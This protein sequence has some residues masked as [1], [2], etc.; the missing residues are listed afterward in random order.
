MEDFYM[1]TKEITNK[2]F[3]CI[4]KQDWDEW[5]GLFDKNVVVDEALSGHLEGIHSMKESADGI[6]RSF[7]EFK[8]YIQEIVVE[9]NKSMV[10]CRIEATTS[11]GFS[12]ESTGANFYKIDN[13]K[14]IY[15]SSFHDKE[16]FLK[17]FASE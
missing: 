3:D 9:D 12:F 2:Y 16:I 7:S 11:R 1:D 4:N 14:I 15:M 13:G 6:K 5:I 10:V 8:N 17:A